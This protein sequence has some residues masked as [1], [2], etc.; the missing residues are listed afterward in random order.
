MLINQYIID[1]SQELPTVTE[2]EKREM[3]KAVSFVYK[4][5]E[6]LPEHA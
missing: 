5:T 4:T 2:V 6:D 3:L 1:N